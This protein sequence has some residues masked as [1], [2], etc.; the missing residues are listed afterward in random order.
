MMAATHQTFPGSEIEYNANRE[1]G[2]KQSMILQCPD[3]TSHT[4]WRSNCHKLKG[5]QPTK[6]VVW[7]ASPM[8]YLGRGVS[9]AGSRTHEKNLLSRQIDVNPKLGPQ[10]L[11]FACTN[12]SLKGLPVSCVL[13]HAYKN[14]PKHSYLSAN[15]S[16]TK[17]QGTEPIAETFFQ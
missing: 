9:T 3:P 1:F 6:V 12:L 14:K 10:N 13:F 4:G 5:E 15:K 7:H 16:V 11:F 8:L 2:L 17:T